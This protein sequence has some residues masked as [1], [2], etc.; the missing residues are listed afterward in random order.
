MPEVVV[1]P[2]DEVGRSLCA[3]R[4]QEGAS[5]EGGFSQ[6]GVLVAGGGISATGSRS[7]MMEDS[8]TAHPAD[9]GVEGPTA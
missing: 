7:A 1:V 6:A 9:L 3:W 2:S 8:H 4:E 5:G